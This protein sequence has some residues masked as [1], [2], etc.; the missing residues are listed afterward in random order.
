MPPPTATDSLRTSGGRPAHGCRRRQRPTCSGHQARPAHARTGSARRS[1]PLATP[2]LVAEVIAWPPALA[3]RPAGGAR[4]A[5]AARCAVPAGTPAAACRRRRRLT[6]SGHRGSPCPWMPAR[7]ATDALGTSGAPAHAPDWL[8]TSEAR[9]WPHP[10]FCGS[11]SLPLATPALAPRPAGRPRSTIAAWPAVGA[12]TPAAGCRR[13]RRLTG[14]GHQ[15]RPAHAPAWFRTSRPAPGTPARLAEVRPAPGH[16]RPPCASQ[17]LPR[18]IPALAPSPPADPLDHHRLTCG[19]ERRLT[20]A[21]GS[22]LLPAPA[23]LA[24]HGFPGSHGP[25]EK[26]VNAPRLASG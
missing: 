23:V 11:N 26:P 17:R 4:S 13:R 16:T 24:A 15:A 10:A 12:A 6:R 20:C 1:P 19:P 9:P 2:A 3:P 25:P 14:S 8:H 18:A 5:I 7:T 21:P 22:H